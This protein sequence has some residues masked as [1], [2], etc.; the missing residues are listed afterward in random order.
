MEFL[1]PESLSKLLLQLP[2]LVCNQTILSANQ[3]TI[4]SNGIPRQNSDWCWRQIYYV[5]LSVIF[6][7][8]PCVYE[9]SFLSSH[10]C[11]CVLSFVFR[12]LAVGG[13]GWG[14]N[15]N[16]ESCCFAQ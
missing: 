15:A 13:T 3:L 9:K 2:C 7:R 5:K 1:L 4:A 6:K 12:P 11:C 10:C 14:K 16:R 8:W